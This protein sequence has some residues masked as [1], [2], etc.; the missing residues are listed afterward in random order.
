MSGILCI[1]ESSYL[2]EIHLVLQYSSIPRRGVLSA[3]LTR[4]FFPCVSAVSRGWLSIYVTFQQPV[5][6]D[7][8]F[9]MGSD[10]RVVSTYTSHVRVY[11]P[12]QDRTE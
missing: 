4:G 12:E 1:P 6:T 10:C 7:L 11:I 3:V 9:L 2:V 5:R 8:R